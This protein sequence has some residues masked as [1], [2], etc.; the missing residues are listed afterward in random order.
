[1]G[2]MTRWGYEVALDDGAEQLPPIIDADQFGIITGGV[3]SSTPDQIAANLDAASQA[4]R[5]WCGWHVAPVLPCSWIGQGEGRQ[6]IL[7]CLAVRSISSIEVNGAQLDGSAYEWRPSGVVRM[8]CGRFPDSWRSV[9]ADFDAGNDA[10]GALGA[11]VAQIAANALA[12]APGVR[13][14]RIGTASVDYNQTASG[15]SGGVRL[16]QSDLD[17]LA[18]YRL[19][20]R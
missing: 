4:V 13:A 10:I 3:M 16:L 11:A 2:I 1:M 5:D 12:A 15:V 9:R 18:P 20:V 8:T 14:E 17:L 19:T 7:P 6:M